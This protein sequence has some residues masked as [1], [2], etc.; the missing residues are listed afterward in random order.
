MASEWDAL[1]LR[2]IREDAQALAACWHTQELAAVL[3]SNPYLAEN[4]TGVRPEDWVILV[5]HVSGVREEDP[6][7]CAERLALYVTTYREAHRKTLT[8]ESVRKTQEPVA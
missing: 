2:E 8:P 4:P 1:S 6:L 5:A 3:A 7:V